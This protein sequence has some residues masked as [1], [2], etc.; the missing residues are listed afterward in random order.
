MAPDVTIAITCYNQ[1]T[2]IGEAI[3]SALAQT[4]PCEI[5]VVDDGSTDDSAGIA[6]AMGVQVVRRRHQ[7][8][9][10]TF[11]AA[12]DMVTT[13][14]YC[15]LNG[16]DALEPSYVEQTR[17]HIQERG[18]GFVYTGWRYVGSMSGVEHARA[19][20]ARE[21]LFGNYVHAASLARRSAYE[22]VGGFDARFSDDFEDWALW[23]AMVRAGW[24]GVAVDAP[25]LRYRRH[26]WPSRNPRSKRVLQRARLRLAMLYPAAYG[27]TGFIRLGASWTRLALRS[28]WPGSA[29]QDLTPGPS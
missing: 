21:L 13:D 22:Q 25:L 10:E 26:D 18:V 1:A 16:D 19:F 7:G 12:V 5:I 6:S 11:R 14:Y 23:V 24:K 17:P 3:R 27:V 15:L 20:D 28:I 4:Y 29:G 8:A 9:V 2:F